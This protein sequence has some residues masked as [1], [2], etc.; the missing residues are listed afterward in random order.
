MSSLNHSLPVAWQAV[1]GLD[2]MQ[3][4]SIYIPFI[5]GSRIRSSKNSN[6]VAMLSNLY[7]QT[8]GT[9]SFNQIAKLLDTTVGNVEELAS[10]IGQTSNS[11]INAQSLQRTVL[12]GNANLSKLPNYTPEVGYL[13]LGIIFMGITIITTA[14]RLYQRSRAPIGLQPVDYALVMAL[15]IALAME[16]LFGTCEFILSSELEQERLTILQL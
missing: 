11:S 10:A 2:V 16:G 13:A 4:L 15:A 5:S 6:A 3:V 1:D 14:L 8:N 7:A 12:W 9:A